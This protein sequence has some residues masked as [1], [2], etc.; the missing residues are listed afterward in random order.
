MATFT[1]KLFL[2]ILAKE[3]GKPGAAGSRLVWIRYPEDV[4]TAEVQIE[5]W[6]WTALQ[7][8]ASDQGVAVS[9]LIRAALEEK[10]YLS[11]ARRRVEA[12]RS[13]QAPWHDREDIGD[14]SGY[15]ERLR[16][17]DRIDRLFQG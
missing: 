5:D 12:F 4:R 6:A 17:D 1:A 15:V 3:S 14:A 11:A 16:Q 9:D 8:L 2:C 10:Y 7:G 13:W